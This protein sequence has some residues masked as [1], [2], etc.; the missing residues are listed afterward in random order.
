MLWVHVGEARYEKSLNA[1]EGVV[2]RS[3]KRVSALLDQFLYPAERPL[4]EDAP[5]RSISVSY[6]Q[7]EWVNT[8]Q[9]IWIFFFLSM[10]FA[11]ALR[12]RLGVTI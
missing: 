11:F 6:P 4:P 7:A 12:N 8:P 2:R 5:V 1:T 10:L 3:A 9:W